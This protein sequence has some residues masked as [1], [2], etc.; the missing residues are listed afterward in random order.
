MKD[1]LLCNFCKTSALILKFRW[2]LVQC[3]CDQCINESLVIISSL[4]LN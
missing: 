3:I 1:T 2:R 4:R